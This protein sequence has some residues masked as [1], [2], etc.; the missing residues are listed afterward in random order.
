MIKLA[1]RPRWRLHHRGKN[2]N[3]IPDLHLDLERRAFGNHR[4]PLESI[5]II[6]RTSHT[7]G[8]QC[9][10]TGNRRA[11]RKSA[12]ERLERKIAQTE[13]LD[14]IMLLLELVE[15]AFLIMDEAFKDLLG[16]SVGISRAF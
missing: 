9:L 5:H 3:R 4:E 2:R 14:V 16:R 10:F 12:A 1:A 6:A 7:S 11:R 13:P 15:V 8:A